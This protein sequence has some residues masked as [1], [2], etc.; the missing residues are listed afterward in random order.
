MTISMREAFAET[1]LM[2]GRIDPNLVVLV[3]DISH[4]I[5]QPFADENPSRYFNIGICEP[6]TVSI[7]AGLSKVGLVPVVHTI[8]PFLIERSF[9]QI[10]LD[11]GY[12]QLGVNLISVGSTFDYAQ[13]GCSHHCYSDA[14]LIAHLPGS[15]VFIPGSNQ[16]FISL[17]DQ[18]YRD[19][20]INYFRLTENPHAVD[21]SEYSIEIGKAINVRHGLDLTLVT[22]GSMLGPVSEAADILEGENISTEVIHYPTFKPFDAESLVRSLEK[23]RHLVV[24][25]E[26]SSSD[27]L[28]NRALAASFGLLDAAPRQLAIE[29]FIHGYGSVKDLRED[30]GL[31]VKHIVRASKDTINK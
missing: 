1:M 22:T 4:G 31:S 13:L 3:G 29:G 14:S 16:E 30:A 11:F 24:I 26:L 28:F 2:T 12:Q 23:T 19:P 7:A 15:R 5:L 21:L 8:A 25:E 18:A 9:E 17:F 20:V 27:G 10:K 6:A